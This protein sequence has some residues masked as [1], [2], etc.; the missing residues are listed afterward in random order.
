MVDINDAR[1]ICHPSN[2]G[3]EITA[4]ILGARRAELDRIRGLGWTVALQDLEL[5][6]VNAHAYL[7]G[8]C[9]KDG[10]REDLMKARAACSKLLLI[11]DADSE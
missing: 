11:L 6:Y 4:D 9:S 8:M 1:D 5:G 7:R 3:R 10:V 2:P